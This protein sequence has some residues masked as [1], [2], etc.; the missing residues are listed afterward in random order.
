MYSGGII[1]GNSEQHI[2]STVD[3]LQGYS[4]KAEM[5]LDC[6]SNHNNL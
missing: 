6:T 1:V 2:S 3:K 4:L 5:G